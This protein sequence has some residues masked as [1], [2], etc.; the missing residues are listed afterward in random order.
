[1]DWWSRVGGGRGGRGGRGRRG[2]HKQLCIHNDLLSGIQ[3][4][5]RRLWRGKLIRWTLGPYAV[6]NVQALK[7]GAKVQAPSGTIT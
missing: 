6:D 5:Q 2:V 7:R 4:P 1:M 3:D